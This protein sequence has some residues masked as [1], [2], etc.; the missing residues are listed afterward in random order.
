MATKQKHGGVR[1]GHS[2]PITRESPESVYSARCEC[3]VSAFGGTEKEALD[4]L[5]ETW[6]GPVEDS[7]R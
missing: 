6:L 5:V 2:V 1:E 3:D 4:A 7:G